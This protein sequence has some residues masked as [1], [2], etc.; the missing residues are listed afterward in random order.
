M[1]RVLFSAFWAGAMLMWLAA[2]VSSD[3]VAQPKTYEEQAVVQEPTAKLIENPVTTMQ[4]QEKSAAEKSPEA[5][6]APKVK[7]PGKPAVVVRSGIRI[8]DAVVC[9]E[10]VDRLPIGT[11]DVFDKGTGKVFCFTRVVGLNDGG[12]IIHNWYY[13]GTLKSTTRL[14]VGSSNW[15]TWS[16]KS[17]NPEFT[18]E[19]MVEVLTEDGRPLESLIFFIQ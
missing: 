9:Q 12:D 17:I 1:K 14:S 19:W 6:P 10:V 16:S 7:S 11:G 5:L 18:G 3:E 13:K 4:Q 15:R 8:K 2:P